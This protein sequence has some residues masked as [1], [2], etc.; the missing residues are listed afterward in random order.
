[1]IWQ[2]SMHI[3]AERKQH[4]LKVIFSEG[5]L[6]GILPTA[7]FKPLAC[8]TVRSSQDESQIRGA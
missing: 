2:R 1:M 7:T 4:L 5:F 8:Y 3:K 6:P